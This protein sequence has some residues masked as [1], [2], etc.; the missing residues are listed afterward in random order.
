MDFDRFELLVNGTEVAH[1]ESTG[2]SYVLQMSDLGEI[3][4]ECTGRYVSL[5]Y[6]LSYSVP[7]IVRGNKTGEIY[8]SIAQLLKT[9]DYLETRLQLK[10]YR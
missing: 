2:V 5:G 7:I 1:G 6:T 9:I 4:V 3:E 8:L 10:L